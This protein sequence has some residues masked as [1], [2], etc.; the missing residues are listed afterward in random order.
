MRARSRIHADNDDTCR[1][2]VLAHRG[3]NLQPDFLAYEDLRSSSLIEL[4]PE[5]SAV[6]LGIFVV[7]PTRKHP[8]RK[9][10]RTLLG[11]ACVGL[12]N[13]ILKPLRNY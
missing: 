7:Y 10:R 9:V 5:F 1:A 3:I 13:Q 8:P 12:V 6:G 2:A 11:D 4:M